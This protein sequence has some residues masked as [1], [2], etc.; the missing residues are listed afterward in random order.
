MHSAG[1]PTPSAPRFGEAAHLVRP[2][3][4]S[5]MEARDVVDYALQRRARLTDL[6]AGRI[7]RGDV[8]DAHP[9]LQLAARHYGA[10]AAHPC[11][12]CTK[13]RLVHVHYVYG[14]ALGRTAGQAKSVGELAVMQSRY[15]D[16]DVYLVEVCGGCGWNHLLRSFVLGQGRDEL[17][18]AAGG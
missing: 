17:S 6:S 12:V 13:S 10:P 11:P 14:E 8:C 1:W 16:F 7:P 2:R 3:T 4:L 9:Y 15:A 18:S 5:R